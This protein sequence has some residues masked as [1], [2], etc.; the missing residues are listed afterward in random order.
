MHVKG[1]QGYL[2][3][4]ERLAERHRAVGAGADALCGAARCFPAV[5]GDAAP[6]G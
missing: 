2:I 1:K 6:R 4:V 5:S 3:P